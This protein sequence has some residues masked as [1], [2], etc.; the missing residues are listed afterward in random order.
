M[1]QALVEQD[2]RVKEAW[3]LPL[4]QYAACLAGLVGGPPAGAPSM[5]H[6]ASDGARQWS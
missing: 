1:G 3:M 5:A 6:R 2:P 4:E